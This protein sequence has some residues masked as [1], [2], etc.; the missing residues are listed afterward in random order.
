MKKISHKDIKRMFIGASN[1]VRN[2]KEKI[3]E[4]NVFPVPDQ[5]TGNNLDITLN[6]VNEVLVNNEIRDITHLKEVVL[7]AALTAASG[8]IGIITT[9]FLS[10]FFSELQNQEIEKEIL[11]KAFATGSK[12]AYESIQDPKEGTILDVIESVAYGMRQ[13]IEKK[14]SDSIIHLLQKAVTF[15][16]EALDK[17]KEKMKLYKNASVVDAGGYGFL[18]MIEG[19]LMGI[20]GKKIDLKIQGKLTRSK[21]IF[22]IQTKKYEVVSLLEEIKIDTK[23]IMDKLVQLGD[24]LDVVEANQKLKI[25]IHTDF[26]GKVVDQI[27]LFGKVIQMKT[28]DMFEALD[29]KRSI[30][31]VTDEAAGLPLK[32]IMDQDIFVVPFKTTWEK[33]D[34][35]GVIQRKNFYDKM[36]TLREETDIYGWPKTSQPSLKMYYQ[37]FKD[38]LKKYEFVLCFTISSGLSGSYNSALQARLMLGSKDRKR[39]FIPDLRQAAGG[40]AILIIKAL[41]LINQKSLS[42]S[43]IEEDIKKL[44]G[45]IRLFGITEDITW[46]A[47]GG[48]FTLGKNLFLRMMRIFKMTP[49]LTLKKGKI[50]MYQF[51]YVK[52]SIGNLLSEVIKENNTGKTEIFI[53]H[54]DNSK[55]LEEIK[56]KLKNS[57]FK[58]IGENILP[59]VLGIHTGPN[60]LIVAFIK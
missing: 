27:A 8:N 26:P 57:R 36:R 25:H 6:A 10:G 20:S 24:S 28:T 41:E 59:E 2:N 43:N 19:F 13:E 1:Q 30:G 46:I 49:I 9:G 44:S 56:S 18:L 4:I 21:K 37:A 3:N 40:Q 17:T 54:A 16:K 50:V 31:I 51:G 45:R 11:A 52:D 32:V 23:Q 22:S 58:I 48:R 15:A 39:I 42:V 5:D 33:A 34:K 35:L 29:N 14:E 53:H 12:K 47:Q 38:Q 55:G 60:S 7:D